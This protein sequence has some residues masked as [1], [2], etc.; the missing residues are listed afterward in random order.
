[1][2]KQLN[3][4]LINK[5]AVKYA[6]TK[7]EEILVE[8]LEQARPMIYN[9]AVKAERRYGIDREDMVSEYMQDVW[10]AVK[11]ESALR[12]DGS[13]NFT[14]RF[15]SFFKKSLLDKLRHNNREMRSAMT[16]VSICVIS[17][18]NSEAPLYSARYD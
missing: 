2:T 5:L 16:T 3:N 17:P 9:E 6:E 11:S 14:Q 13:S 18:C 7:S 1:M 8:I 12:F 15:H 4:E 10:E